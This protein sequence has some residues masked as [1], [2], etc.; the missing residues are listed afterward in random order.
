MTLALLPFLRSTSVIRWRVKAFLSLGYYNKYHTLSGKQQAFL[1]HGLEIQIRMSAY[2]SP[3]E[4]LPSWSHM[5]FFGVC[6]QR[7]RSSPSSLYKG[8]KPI[9]GAYLYNLIIFQE[10]NLQMPLHWELLIQHMN[11]EGTKH[12]VHSPNVVIDS[13][14]DHQQMLAPLNERLLKKDIHIVSKQQQIMAFLGQLRK[15][16][17]IY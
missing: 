1:F 4:D 12:S 15:F 3:C 10:P 9:I 5:S 6:M 8:I 7:Q 17:N 11:L 2:L 14:K 16:E 13:G